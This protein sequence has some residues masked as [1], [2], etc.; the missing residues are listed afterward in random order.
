MPA[1]PVGAPGVVPG[2]ATAADGSDQGPGSGFTART[3]KIHEVPLASPPTTR[4]V[5]GSATE[6]A[7]VHGVPV[8]GALSTSYPVTAG[9]P[10]ATD[11][12][13]VTVISPAPVTVPAPATFVGLVSAKTASSEVEVTVISGNS[14]PYPTVFSATTR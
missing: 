6:P 3:W 10:S 9:T 4:L 8:D 2:I 7:I 12:S 1:R 14:A 13:H 5:L 11:G